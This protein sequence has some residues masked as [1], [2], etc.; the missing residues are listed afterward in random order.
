MNTGEYVHSQSSLGA[1][2]ITGGPLHGPIGKLYLVDDRYGVGKW[3][4]GRVQCA[5]LGVGIICAFCNGCLLELRI[6]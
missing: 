3:L 5:E 2:G 1:V 6:F 4:V